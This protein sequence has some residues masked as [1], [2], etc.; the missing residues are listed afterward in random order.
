[1]IIENQRIE[2]KTYE[3]LLEE[4]KQER[5][6]LESQEPTFFETTGAALRTS[7][8]GAST[9]LNMVD[10]KQMMP[11]N[12]GDVSYYD[13]DEFKEIIKQVSPNITSG[14]L[15]EAKE[16]RNK[17]Y[18]LA[19]LNNQK[20]WHSAVDTIE[21]AGIS[22]MA[23]EMVVSLADIPSW[24]VGGAVFKAGKTAVNALNVQR[25]GAKL[26]GD[27]AV[28]SASAGGAIGASEMLIQEESS[29]SDKERVETVAKFGAAFGVALPLLGKSF[30]TVA[31]G[32]GRRALADNTL[33]I[34]NKIPGS[35]SL[36][37]F[38][39]LSS[40]D[41]LIHQSVSPT[42]RNIGERATTKVTAA[43]DENGNFITQ[44]EDT[45]MDYVEQTQN[46]RV[47]N[48]ILN[49]NDNAK[50]RG[51]KPEEA[52]L[53]YGGTF[54]RF[55]N[56]VE[57][58]VRNEITTLS[59]EQQYRLY[60]QSTGTPLKTEDINV[61]TR[62]NPVMETRIIEPDDL[63]DVLTASIRSKNFDDGK[64]II[65]NHLK[66]IEDFYKSYG[67]DATT[68]EL[69]GIGGKDSRGYG[70]IK[71][72]E[73]EILA[74]EVEALRKIE[75]MLMAD[76]LNQHLIRQGE[77]TVEEV[78]KI[79]SNMIEKALDRDLKNKY[80]DGA[81]G[82][83]SSSAF[84]HRR[85]RMDRSLY[86]EMFVND[87]QVIATE[88][89]DR[90]G[91][92]IA[93]KKT[94]GI[95]SDASGSIKGSIKEVLDTVAREG[96][97]AGASRRAIKRD[98]ENTRAVLETILGSRK[99]NE[100][101]DAAVQKT[102]RMLKKGASALFNAGFIK[103]ALV[104]STVAVMRYGGKAVINNF[105]PAYKQISEHISKADATDPIVKLFRQAG[106]ATSTLRG[107]R[108]DRYDNLEITPTT[109]KAEM[110]LDKSAHWGRKY[111]GFNWINDIN[112]ALAGG[113]ALTEL[114]NVLAR[115]NNLTTAEASRFARF[116]LTSNDIKAISRQNL[117]LAP[118]GVVRNWNHNNWRDEELA[119]KFVR[120]LS[121]AVRDTVVRADGTRVHRWQS[122][123][124]NP[125]ATMGLQFTQM[126]VALYERLLLN[127]YDELSARTIVGMSS[128]VMGMYMILSLEEK[129]LVASGAKDEED[130]NTTLWIK[131]ATRTPFAGIV[132]NFI[133]VGLMATGNAPLGSSYKPH[134][135]AASQFLGAGYSVGNR[136]F[137]AFRGLGDGINETDAASFLRITPIIN[138]F[139]GL[140]Y[141]MK[142]VERD[143]I[144]QGSFDSDE[145][146]QYDKPLY[147]LM[148]D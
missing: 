115:A 7:V 44:V 121:R 87:V 57:Q 144:K 136:V 4:G 90:V 28:T 5:E 96:K 93:L 124:N 20:K 76:K 106:L 42:A 25:S 91:G 73:E 43:R 56:A 63:Y 141:L 137:E 110:F 11:N 126:P 100:N 38:L 51:I 16:A 67:A 79:A 39:S 13:S 33:N 109:G 22:G 84:G 36:R 101:P 30:T 17:D 58:D 10:R 21:K 107:M 85:L 32:E 117:E 61:G 41:Q 125:I 49:V 60:E 47:S 6:F 80:I 108:Y 31:T 12:E 69:K 95:D 132:P 86:P 77:L 29:V 34:M 8:T 46:Q 116:G 98:V 68:Y 128:A 66:Y 82:A 133:D 26:L 147:E 50:A 127:G 15:T 75:E 74:D 92:R 72:N 102:A 142:G 83:Q 19:T 52:A 120:Y 9:F 103:Y 139:P 70:H 3:E 135:D 148:K 23:T 145:P 111:S 27:M 78:K 14:D 134:T 130:D 140:S 89:A 119:K 94:Y 113:S 129:A 88:Y 146:I 114:Q 24:F 118:D 112:D 65:P 48:I 99:Y 104:E 62:D 138:A 105:I 18:L 35:G 1:M 81:G 143:L 123:V 55:T 53:E 59:K 45:A 71:Y 37:G 40:A 64:Y 97:E 131:A 54:N 2:G 122:D